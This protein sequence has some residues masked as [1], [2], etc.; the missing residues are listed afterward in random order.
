MLGQ[1][2][3]FWV[4]RL[5]LVY[6]AGFLLLLPFVGVVM[7]VLEVDSLGCWFCFFL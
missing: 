1:G 7:C 6:L 2:V 5:V 4:S 3:G